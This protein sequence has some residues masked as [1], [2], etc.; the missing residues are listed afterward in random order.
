METN[1]LK[2]W[3]FERRS[4]GN[5]VINGNIYNDIKCRFRDGTPIH[6]SRVLKADFVNGVVETKNSVYHL[7]MRKENEAH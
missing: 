6:T 5:V 1:Y 4:D 2:N 3:Y 7:E